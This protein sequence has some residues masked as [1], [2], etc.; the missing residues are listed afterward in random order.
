MACLQTRTAYDKQT[1]SGVPQALSLRVLPVNPPSSHKVSMS[2]HLPDVITHLF[3]TPAF[4]PKGALCSPQGLTIPWKW[5]QAT[6]ATS[7]GRT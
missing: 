1:E 5:G 4:P 2:C 7:N 6:P 3:L